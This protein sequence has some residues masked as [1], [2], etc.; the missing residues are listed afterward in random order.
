M[1]GKEETLVGRRRPAG[2]ERSLVGQGLDSHRGRSR[3]DVIRVGR[4]QIRVIMSAGESTAQAASQHETQQV[5]DVAGI[6]GDDWQ[7]P[8]AE[9]PWHPP[10]VPEATGDGP[11]AGAQPEPA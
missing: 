1:G 9:G 6:R 5:I 10:G 3:V 2:G 11:E 4:T 8:Q 7:P